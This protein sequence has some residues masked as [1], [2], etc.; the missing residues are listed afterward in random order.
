[1]LGVFVSGWPAV[2]LVAALPEIGDNLDAS[3]STLSWVLSL[4]MLIGAVMLPTFGRLGDLKGQRRVFL[5]GLTVCGLAAILTALSWNAASLIIFR[6]I[7]QTAG[8]AT[9]PTAVALIMET[10]PLDSRPRALG[11]WAFVSAA[12]PAL[13]L[14]FGGPMVEALSWRGVFIAQGALALLFLPLC[15]RW[16]DETKRRSN[17]GFDVLGGITL[18]LATGSILLYLDRGGTW[19][20]TNPVELALLVAAPILGVAFFRIERVAKFPLL[21][22]GLLA[23]PAYSMPAVSEFLS[24]ASSNA[25]FFSAPLLLTQRFEKSVAETAFLMLPLP[26]GMCFGA[27]IGGRVA[28]RFGERRAGLIGTTAMALS[29]ALFLI[30]YNTEVMIVVTIALIVQGIANGFVRPAVASAGGAALSPEYF[31]V[32]MAT[33][34]MIAL[35]GSTMGISI[36]LAASVIGGF[37]AIYVTTFV[38]AMLA[39]LTMTRVVSHKRLTGTPEERK[40]QERALLAEMETEAGLTTLPAFEG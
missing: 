11:M 31:G 16:L 30:G 21:P 35:L 23:N 34:R 3:A 39:T 33:L 2:I 5:I 20:W 1:M 13:G 18:M 22:A 10:F 7:S 12:A 14:A 27:I 25:V 36:A 24:Q 9:A 26:L 32:G 6:T 15:L 29:M 17:I 4:P 38:L 37:R 40:A 19:G 28:A 8:F